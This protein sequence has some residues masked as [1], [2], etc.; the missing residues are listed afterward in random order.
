MFGEWIPHQCIFSAWFLVQVTILD[1]VPTTT[2]RSSHD[3]EGHGDEKDPHEHSYCPQQSS[4][5]S[6]WV[7]IAVPN[8]SER[9]DAP[10]ECVGDRRE[11][12]S[13]FER[14]HSVIIQLIMRD[15][16]QGA[17]IIPKRYA[18]TPFP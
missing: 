17:S 12:R 9:D 8:S 18:L 10:P 15:V 5:A 14:L 6:S 13:L 11:H 16:A 4:N 7:H 1:P 2:E 3:R